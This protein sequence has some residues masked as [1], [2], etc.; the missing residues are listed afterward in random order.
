MAGSQPIAQAAIAD[1]STAETKAKN[2]SVIALSYCVG[3]VLGPF[4]GGVTSDPTISPWFSFSMPFYIATV[5]SAIAFFWLHW[6]FVETY[7]VTERKPVHILRP[8]K[9]FIEAFEHREVR[10]LAIVFLL[11]QMGFSLYFQYIIVQME[12]D[13]G[14]SNAL[15]GG[16]QAMIGIGF[17][18]GLLIGIPLALKFWQVLTIAIITGLLTGLGQ[19][20][21]AFVTVAS[22]QWVLAFVVACVNIMVF[23]AMLTL[24]SDAVS[25]KSQGWVM[26]IA[27]AVLACA[28]AVTGLM[29]NLLDIVSTR[30][31]IFF[32][33]VCMIAASLWLL[34]KGVI[35]YEEQ[36]H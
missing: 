17:A 1:L 14:Y 11:M 19:F 36:S 3:S 24:F 16:V 2:M 12:H 26:G 20:I 9:I 8:I 30:G 21:V 4:I 27:N 15:L 13:Y 28:W 7:Q 22:L 25:Q 23:T 31:L 34:K 18:V 6:G 10:T 5:L 35:K 33:G 29:S 32:G